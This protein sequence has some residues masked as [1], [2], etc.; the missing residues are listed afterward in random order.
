[1]IRAVTCFVKA[2]L[3]AK[4]NVQLPGLVKQRVY[5]IVYTIMPLLLVHLLEAR[6]A[7]KRT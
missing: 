3:S 1:M 4:A 7:P 2:F 5:C 6:I